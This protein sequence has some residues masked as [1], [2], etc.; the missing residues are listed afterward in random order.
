MPDTEE[1]AEELLSCLG[2]RT[3]TVEDI[4]QSGS[5]IQASGWRPWHTGEKKQG[6]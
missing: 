3:A 6:P 2:Y 4:R 5:G 1:A